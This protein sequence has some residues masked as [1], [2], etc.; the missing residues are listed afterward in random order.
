MARRSGLERTLDDLSI[1]P[2]W[3]LLLLAPVA[4]VVI[5][6]GLP[7]I[8]LG[9]PLPLGILP[10]LSMF[11]WV[12]ALILVMASIGSFIRSRNRRR[13][14]ERQHG[15]ETI[16]ALSWPEFEQLVGE[17]YRRQGYSVTETGK[18][19]PDG[20]VDVTLRK[21][22]ETVLVQCKHWR[23]QSIGVPIVREL[24]GAVTAASASRGIVV[25]SGKFTKP[26]VD[27]ARENRIELVD[28]ETLTRFVAAVQ[29]GSQFPQQDLEPP[30]SAPVIKKV[31]ITNDVACPACGGEMI[32]RVA[33]RGVNAGNRFLGCS[34]YPSCRGTRSFDDKVSLT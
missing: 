9:N 28:G 19:G 25:G 10:A 1:F 11:A 24:L 27:F 5:R 17:A 14:L 34:H 21:D 16:R 3:L 20:G 33:K 2:W 13:L 26:A 22:G 4:Y 8:D 23:S 29:D 7:L 18:A 6:F 12:P 15:I 30:A 32:E 31:S